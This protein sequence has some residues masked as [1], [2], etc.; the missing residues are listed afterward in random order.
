MSV[1]RVRCPC[2]GKLSCELCHGERFY[3]YEVGP[4]GWMPFTCP[5]CRGAGM[6]TVPPAAPPVAPGNGDTEPCPTCHGDGTI[7]PGNPPLAEGSVGL[8]RK[9]WKIFMGG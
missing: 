7:D 8:I 4:R 9:I 5:T 1:R 6:L 2:R 3:D